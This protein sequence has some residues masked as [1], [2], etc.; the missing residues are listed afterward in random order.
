[1]KEWE[2]L[3][4]EAEKL[5][6]EEVDKNPVHPNDQDCQQEY[7][8]GGADHD[9]NGDSADYS[10][11]EPEESGDEIDDH[12]ANLNLEMNRVFHGRCKEHQKI[13]TQKLEGMGRRLLPSPVRTCILYCSMF[14][15]NESDR[16]GRFRSCPH[17]YIRANEK[18]N[19]GAWCVKNT[20]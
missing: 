17:W 5:L 1:M 10:D 4:L 7:D 9:N 20:Q 19:S 14:I 8:Y 16:R 15:R 11:Y 12:M 13:L 3:L 6:R 18:K 2:G